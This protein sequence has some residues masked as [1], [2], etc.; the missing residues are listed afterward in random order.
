MVK[1]VSV[2]KNS[3]AGH[4]GL[5]SGDVLISINGREINDVLDYRFFLAERQIVLKFS[6]DGNVM[7]VIIKKQQYDDIGLDFET[8]LMDK[9]H[10]CE[11]KCIFCFIDQLPKGMRKTLYFKDDDSRLSFLHGNYITLTNL[12]DKDIDRIIEMHISPVNVSVHTTNPELR[13]KMMHNKRAGEVLSYMKRLADA[14]ISLCGQIVLCKGINDG[15]ELERSMRD[16]SELYPAMQS[17]SIVPAGLTKYREK[18]YPLEHF[19][20]D[21]AAQVIDQVDSFAEK[22]KA[23]HGVRMFYCADELYL[24]A[25]RALPDEDYYDGYPQIENGVGMITSTL[26]EF[27]DELDYICEYIDKVTLPRTVSIATGEAAYSLI[28][29][30]A[31]KLE[32][33]IDG[34]KIHVFK[35]ANTFFGESIT[36]AGLLTGR[37]IAT[38]LAGKEL[39]ELLLFPENALRADGD[40]FLDD[41]SPEELGAQLGVTALPGHNDGAQ[42]ICDV[43]GV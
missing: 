4:A 13:V 17:V 39:G 32:E 21:E 36:V 8:P 19:T 9:K 20:K 41:M 27:Y 7:E 6:R 33:K 22:I 24:K 10:S 29:A 26:T 35:V 15:E 16:L 37:D 31:M 38:Q 1:I 30:M 12:H 5:I 40:L 18:L 43:L 28:K 2:D 25:E 3:R 34:L 42:F 14:G 11:N 23:E